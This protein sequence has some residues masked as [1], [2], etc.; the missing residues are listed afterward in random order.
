MY[1]EED[2][3]NIDAAF[4]E[5]YYAPVTLG[6]GMLAAALVIGA[7][8]RRW[9]RYGSPFLPYASRCLRLRWL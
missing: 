1:V 8:S 4:L 7:L 3:S 6:L 5:R 2:L 9:P